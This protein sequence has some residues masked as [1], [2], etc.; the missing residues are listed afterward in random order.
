MIEFPALSCLR[1]EVDDLSG[2]YSQQVKFRS[3]SKTLT[4]KGEDFLIPI[5][6]PTYAFTL[7]VVSG[8]GIRI[9]TPVQG[10]PVRYAGPFG[11]SR[12]PASDSISLRGKTL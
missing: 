5:P 12:R 9:T 10:L 8:P 11:I 3:V 1:G 2:R 7:V 4:I 6:Y